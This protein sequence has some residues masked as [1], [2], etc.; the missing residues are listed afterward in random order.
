MA[1]KRKTRRRARQVQEPDAQD[2]LYGVREPTTD[3]FSSGCTLL[4][5]VLGGGWAYSR[6]ANIIGDKSTGKTLLAIEACANFVVAN[7]DGKV[8]YVE[9]EAAFDEDYAESLGL[10]LGRVEFPEEIDT[11]ED[12]F[13][14][15]DER[16]NEDVRTLYIVDSMDALGDR[17]E[18]NR[19]IDDGSYG[20]NKQKRIGELFRR[21]IRKF[22][23]SNVTLI[24]I[25]QVRE[26]IGVAFGDKLKRSGGRA[27]DF[28]ATHALWLAHLGQIKRTHN[29]VQRAV[30]VRVKAKCKK[31]KIGPPFRECEFP[32]L[33]N[34]GVE[35]VQ[36]GLEWLASV[37]RT[38]A[39]GMTKDNAKR[40]AAKLHKLDDAAYAEEQRNVREAVVEV[41]DKIESSFK[42]ARRK[43]K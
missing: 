10:P 16:M 19:K 31:N 8:V 21:M 38:D 11:V 14:D 30:G 29:K 27:L 17:A 36:A 24:I 9:A 12:L 28:Y 43:Y 18:Q 41:W 40:L 1:S 15:L 35:D 7:P 22:K 3:T 42:P 5:Q 32:L 23:R 25:S 34:Y 4:D 20:M 39:I 37:D 26:A 33:F 6:V 2:D 13:E